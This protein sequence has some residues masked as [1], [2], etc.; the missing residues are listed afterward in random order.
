M[1]KSFIIIALSLA[2]APFSPAQDP[3]LNDQKEKVSYS[4][5]LDIGGTLKR[6][7][8]DVNEELLNRGI[9]D[10]LSGGKPL[11]TDEQV[12]EVMA[13]FQKDMIA[14]Q[15]AV[16]KASGE[17]NSAAGKK[18]LEANKAKD[19]V[20]TTASGLQYKV[21]KEGSGPLP[22]ATDTV[23]VNYRGTTIDGKEFDSSYK[24]NE[25]ATF[26]VNRVIK[27]WTE[28]LQLM[29]VGSKY[30]LV[31]PSDLAYGERGA[32]QDIGP[33]S[34]LVFDVELLGIEPPAAPVKPATYDSSRPA[35]QPGAAIPPKPAASPAA[36]TGPS[37]QA[38]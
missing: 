9:K 1:K 13:A 21:E 22:K 26:P 7:L 37:P 28:A 16:K 2:F 15:A 20:K 10:G 38:P 18:F 29:K 8:I 34:T 23:K 30:H 17:K 25:P 33:D 6:Q 14:K 5:G 19:G 31:I 36:S 27:G 24:R 3:K 11:L 12:K 35:G 4:I 32:G